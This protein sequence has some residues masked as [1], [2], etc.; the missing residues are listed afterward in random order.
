MKTCKTCGKV[1]APDDFYSGQREC[2][3]CKIQRSVRHRVNNPEKHRE[4]A[5][6]Q[7]EQY[8]S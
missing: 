8:K 2:K 4:Y 3:P 5:K 1:K 7:R 6:T